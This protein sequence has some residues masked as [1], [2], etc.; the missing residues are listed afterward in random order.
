[1]GVY[2]YIE[3]GWGGDWGERGYNLKFFK[4]IDQNIFSLQKLCQIHNS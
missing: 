1:M 2:Q 3:G 4:K